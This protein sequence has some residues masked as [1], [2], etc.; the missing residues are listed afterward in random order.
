MTT[1]TRLPLRYGDQA[2][3]A[4]VSPSLPPDQ[5]II[6]DSCFQK[7]IELDI[8]PSPVDFIWSS[9]FG[10]QKYSFRCSIV[11]KSLTM[12]TMKAQKKTWLEPPRQ[13]SLAQ[14]EADFGIKLFALASS[15]FKSGPPHLAKVTHECL[16]AM[17][18]AF[19]TD[20]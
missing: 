14:P 13:G 9:Y 17:K 11:H 6:L 3:N 15:E 12:V 5:A 7:L 4:P 1:V 2:K 8:E 16:C 10:L 18:L 20:S 19:K